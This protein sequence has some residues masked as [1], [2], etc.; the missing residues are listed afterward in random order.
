MPVG[1]IGEPDLPQRP[2]YPAVGV[3][4]GAFNVPCSTQAGVSRFAQALAA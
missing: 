3:A 2:A 4:M 1:G